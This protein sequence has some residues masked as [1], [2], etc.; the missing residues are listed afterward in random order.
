MEQ[1][2]NFTFQEAK[3]LEEVR[4]SPIRSMIDKVAALRKEGKNVISF[5]AGEPDFN[6]PAAIKEATISALNQNFTHY[7]SNHGY[8]LL[9]EK[10]SELFYLDTGAVYE[11]STEVLVTCGGAEAINHA[12]LATINPGDEVIIFTPSFVN[13][14]NLVRLCGGTVV[15]IPLKAENRFQIDLEET[16]AHINSNTKMIILNNPCNPTGSVYTK[17]TLT[18]LAALVQKHELLLFSD[19]I[20]SKLTYDTPFTSIATFPEIRKQSIILGGFSKTYAMTGWRLGYLLADKE[21]FPSLLKIHQYTST[22]CPTF[23]QVGLAN[24]ITLPDTVS[25]VNHMIATFKDRRNLMMSMLQKITTLNCVTPNGAFYLFI[26]VSATGLTGQDFA[27]RLLKE[28]LVAT[29]PGIGFG[30]EFGNFIRLSYA[31]S[32]ENIAEGMKRL[33]DFVV[34]L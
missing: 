18:G 19:E 17:E 6:T 33:Q 16:M 11:P 31:T 24:S 28:Q 21:L 12:L 4:F 29:V 27:D 3:R 14:E 30:K 2:R 32:T 25:E 7:G 1:N 22:C 13:Y 20:Y 8:P 34:S 5:V 10:I 15:A 23:L 9:C 26:D